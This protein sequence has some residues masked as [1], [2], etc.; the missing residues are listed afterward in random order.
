MQAAARQPP[1]SPAISRPT[2]WQYDMRRPARMPSPLSGARIVVQRPSERAGRAGCGARGARIRLDMPRFHE[3]GCPIWF[4]HGSSRRPR[5]SKPDPRA[6]ILAT[7]EEG[8]MCLGGPRLSHLTRGVSGRT[9]FCR[10]GTS[11]SLQ[12]TESL[13]HSNAVARQCSLVPP[14]ERA[15]AFSY[16][17][18]KPSGRRRPSPSFQKEVCDSP[19]LL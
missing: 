2:P 14:N 18:A 17:V 1:D 6:A 15:T 19:R 7:Q 12:S 5:S 13:R 8:A 4:E 16:T 9:P 11:G 3:Y 10:A